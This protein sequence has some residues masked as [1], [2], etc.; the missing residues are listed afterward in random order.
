MPS[1]V[2]ENHLQARRQDQERLGLRRNP[3]NQDRQFVLLLAEQDIFPSP[4]ANPNDLLT[5]PILG[6]ILRPQLA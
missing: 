3:G 5:K 4:E 1:L 6:S 2:L